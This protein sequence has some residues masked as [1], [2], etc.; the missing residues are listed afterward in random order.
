MYRESDLMTCLFGLIGW[1]QNDN[2]EYPTLP[3]ELIASS[4]GL[5]FQDTHPLV[6]IENLDQGLKNYD[7]FVYPDFEQNAA[8]EQDDRVRDPESHIV[9]EAIHDIADSGSAPDYVNDWV[10]VNLLAQKL[11]A[12]TKAAINKVAAAVFTKKKLDRVAKTVLESV[13]LFS[14]VGDFSNREVKAGRFVGL[15]ISVNNIADLTAVIR[16]IGTQFSGANP[17]LS[18]WLWHSSSQV[19]IQEIVMPSLAANAFQWSNK[20]IL[21]KD[22]GENQQVGGYYYLGYYESDLVG[23]AINKLYDFSSAPACTTCNSDHAYY[24]AWSRYVSIMPFYVPAAYIP[25]EDPIN[26]GPQLWDLNVTQYNYQNNFGLNLDL[27]VRCDV[28]DLLCKERDVFTQALGLQVAVDALTE[29]AFSTRNNVI[30]KETRDLADYALKDVAGNQGLVSRLD[31]AL[32]ALAFDLSDLNRV[33]LP[34]DNA[35]GVQYAAM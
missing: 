34:C 26:P 19:P 20:E 13:P 12:L 1:R 7:H 29:I 4:S 25:D 31:K 27:S 2:P 24:M 28:T 5:Y 18:L 22:L 30:A 17:G 35:N 15:Q 23:M 8:Y 16:R 11:E 9:Y 21:L 14:G 3:P 10:E 32:D 6:S 33:C